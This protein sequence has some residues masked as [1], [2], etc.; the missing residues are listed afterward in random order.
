MALVLAPKPLE[1]TNH[2]YR[3]DKELDAGRFFASNND[4]YV[5]YMSRI[6]H[7]FLASLISGKI[8]FKGIKLAYIVDYLQ[9]AY[10][11]RPM[12]ITLKT[13][14]DRLKELENTNI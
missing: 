7:G 2:H 5:L 14:S 6:I 12:E 11:F 10:D 4:V 3:Y 13:G 8:S 1:F 9:Y